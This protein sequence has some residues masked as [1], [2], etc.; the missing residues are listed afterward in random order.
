MT[1]GRLA[2]FVKEGRKACRTEEEQR[3][4]DRNKAL[5]DLSCIPSNVENNIVEAY[6]RQEPKGDKMSIYNYLVSHRCR[7]LLDDIE[8][9]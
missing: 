9:F 6:I 3:N 5:I 2:E 1:A 4:W 7:L 8:E